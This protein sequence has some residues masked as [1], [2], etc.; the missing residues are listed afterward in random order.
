MVINGCVP[1]M[2]GLEVLNCQNWNWKVYIY[3][4]YFI[5]FCLFISNSG[6]Q[7]SSQGAYPPNAMQDDELAAGLFEST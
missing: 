4:L 5:L 3:C 2:Q 7:L 6:A 1:G